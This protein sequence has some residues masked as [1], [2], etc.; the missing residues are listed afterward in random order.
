M[1]GEQLQQ[2][3]HSLQNLLNTETL[4]RY[5]VIP[6]FYDQGETREMFARARKL[7]DEFEIEG[8]PM[9]SCPFLRV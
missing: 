2:H 9:V 7:L 1:T 8:H 5:L 3:I 4:S 6:G